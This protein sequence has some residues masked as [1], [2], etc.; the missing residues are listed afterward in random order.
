MDY[1]S[2]TG[3]HSKTRTWIIKGL[4]DFDVADKIMK[5]HGHS[6]EFMLKEEIC[7]ICAICEKVIINY[8]LEI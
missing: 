1:L 7:V 6:W 2:Q 3:A 5:I 8:Q 4:A